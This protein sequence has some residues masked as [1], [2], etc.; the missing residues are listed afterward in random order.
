MVV[1]KYGNYERKFVVTTRN[2]VSGVA[3]IFV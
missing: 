3:L 2:R 1:D